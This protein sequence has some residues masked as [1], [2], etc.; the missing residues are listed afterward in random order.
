MKKP[1]LKELIPMTE[2]E[3]VHYL[4]VLVELKLFSITEAIKESDI[5]NKDVQIEK[6]IQR[7]V[8]ELPSHL[9]DIPDVEKEVRNILEETEKKHEELKKVKGKS[10]SERNRGEER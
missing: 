2:D 9:S 6:T 10:D 1:S 8:Q 5:E 7:F 3:K 4:S